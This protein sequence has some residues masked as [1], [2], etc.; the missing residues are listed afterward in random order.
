MAPL[1]TH[2]FSFRPLSILVP[3]NPSLPGNRQRRGNAPPLPFVLYLPLFRRP[4]SLFFSSPGGTVH[5]G[6]RFAFRFFSSAALPRFFLFFFSASPGPRT[7]VPSKMHP[8]T[9]P[10]SGLGKIRP[11]AFLHPLPSQE[12]SKWASSLEDVTSRFFSP[13]VFIGVNPTVV[14]SRLP[15]PEV[16]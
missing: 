6:S 5:T 10:L 16:A 9:F 13:P 15:P 14:G 4:R 12:L 3:P 8:L 11:A 1:A 2:F 7:K